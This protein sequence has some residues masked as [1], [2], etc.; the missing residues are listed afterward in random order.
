MHIAQCIHS[1]MRIK[2][3]QQKRIKPSHIFYAI[4]L[5]S[6][7]NDEIILMPVDVSKLC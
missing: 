1:M 5:Q 2:A 3:M 7:Q 4:H 6:H